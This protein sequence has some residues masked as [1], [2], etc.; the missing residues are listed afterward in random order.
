MTRIIAFL[1]KYKMQNPR[2][3]QFWGFALGSPI[4]QV[5]NYKLEAGSV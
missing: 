3:F 4:G 1:S 5:Q 2:T